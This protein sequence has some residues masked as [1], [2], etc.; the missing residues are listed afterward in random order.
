V[1]KLPVSDVVVLI[2]GITGSV[3]QRHGE[4]VWAFTPGA[5]LK[6]VFSFGD[7]IT[8]LELSGD[9]WRMDDLGDGVTADRVM[10]DLHL[11]PGFWKIDGYGE[12]TEFL[13]DN[14]T[15]EDKEN[16]FNFPYDWRRDNRAS[17][18]S[19]E[20]QAGQ[21]LTRWRDR[22]GNDEAKLVLIGHSMGG[23]IARYFVEAL[24]G[25]KQT[26]AVI[27]FGTPF[28]GSVNAIDFLVA[29]LRKGIGP[30]AV[31]LSPMLRSFTSVHQLVPIYRCVFEAAGNQVSPINAAL[32]GWQK[33][34]TKNLSEFHEEME[35]AA[36]LNRQDPRWE[37]EGPVYQ[38]IVGD[39]QKTRQSVRMV[40]SKVE[41]LFEL[42]GKDGGGDGTVPRISAALAGTET[43][44]MFTPYQHARLQ[45]HGP[46]LDHMKGLMRSLHELTIEEVRSLEMPDERDVVTM[47]FSYSGE[48]VYAEGAPIT[49]ELALV[50][51]LD[52]SQLP[53]AN[54]T[55]RVTNRET[56]EVAAMKTLEV[57]P[58]RGA[59][60][61]EPLPSG[62]YTIA[63]E[64]PEG[65][66]PVTDVFLIVGEVLA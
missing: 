39:D 15:L 21:W 40:D 33:T 53:S 9:D 10:P 52:A 6:G 7:S 45:N 59:Y 16:F 34:W 51:G 3:L 38:P 60:E 55:V 58:E 46:V 20:R 50:S 44:R 48:D 14:F 23:L 56:R 27:T 66:T 12:A 17:A 11:I 57:I 32:P 61:L 62:S 31:D 4:D 49:F 5:L 65:S 42:S 26:K 13:L 8:S 22:S 24:G 1:A 19:L 30:F 43:A 54:V 29:G 37:R 18:R 63:V 2:P 41:A 28:Y 35:S 25:W 64:G 47:W 36:K